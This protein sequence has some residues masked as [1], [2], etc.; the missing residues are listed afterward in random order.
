VDQ[1]L[2]NEQH[3]KNILAIKDGFEEQQKQLSIE[4]SGPLEIS[5]TRKGLKEIAL[6]SPMLGEKE[7]TLNL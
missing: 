3:L 4:N 2:G 6:N 1:S 5:N 7:L